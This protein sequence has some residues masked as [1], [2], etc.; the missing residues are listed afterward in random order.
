MDAMPELSHGDVFAGCR[1]EAL[2]GRGGMGVV[3]RAVQLD[4]GRAVALKVIAADR[5]ADPE[6]RERFQ[7]ESRMAAAIDHPNVVPVHAAGQERDQLYLVMRYVAGSDLHAVIKRGGPLAPAR[8]AAIVAHVASALD[9]AHAAGLVHRDVK[10]ANVLL[11]S[12]NGDGREHV[13]LSDFGLM[14]LLEPDTQLT[15]SGQWIGTID[16]ASAEQLHGGRLDARSD[17]YSLGCVLYAALTGAPP[18]VRGTIPATLL[19]H[20]HDPPPRPSEHGAPPE[21]DRVVARALA[22]APEDR[23]PSAGDLGRAALAAARGEAVSETERSVAVGVAAPAAPAPGEGETAPAAGADADRGGETA[24]TAR[25]AP[26]GQT[27]RDET[28]ATGRP[29]PAGETDASDKTAATARPAP[30][31]QTAPAGEPAATA[32]PAPAGETAATRHPTRVAAAGDGRTAVA[33]P[34]PG[35]SPARRLRERVARLGRA[36]IPRTGVA[37][38]AAGGALLLLAAGAVAVAAG[39]LGGAERAAADDRPLRAAEVRDVAQAFAAAYETEDAGALARL[40]APDARRVLPTGTAR[41]AQAIAGE[42]AAQFRDNVTL[43][44]EL[45]GLDA[46]GGRVGRASAAYRVRREDGD[47][48]EGTIVLGVVRDGAGEPRIALLAVTPR[49]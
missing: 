14:R 13:Y 38:L 19:A 29:A 18:F 26:A 2:L 44:Y 9:A 23:Y 17:V 16:F 31:G 28:A 7:R 35:S 30:A 15:E 27:V 24:A 36:A 37:K 47:S 20:M 34:P 11:G 33:A 8:A 46:R 42:Y 4:L 49:A 1:I 41:G 43:G 12:A 10:P 21:F 45:D 48:L 39:A 40:L 32:R 5:A 25:P 22:K 3:Y 6:F